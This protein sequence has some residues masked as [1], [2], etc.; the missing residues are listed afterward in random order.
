[1]D[2]NYLIEYID[3]RIE[4]IDKEN[5]L[6]VELEENI[7]MKN[8]I[9]LEIDD[10]KKNMNL[11]YGKYLKELDK[12]IG[13]G[14]VKQELKKLINYLIFVKKTKNK[15]HL[16]NINLNMV[17]RGNPGTGKTTVARIVAKILCELGFLKS[18]CVIETTPRDFIAGYIGQTAIQSRETI[19]KAKGGV[20]F[21][22]EAYTFAQSA[23]DDGKTFVYEAITEIIKEMESGNTAFIFS[24]YSKEMDKFIELNPGIK[25]RIA[26][27]IN[28][29]NYTK[30]ELFKMFDNKV[31][32]AGLGAVGIK[33]D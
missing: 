15:V 8:K 4:E 22:D 13:L 5:N 20:I 29:V 12:L 31:K 24:G 2:V 1:M 32:D 21:I 26:Y 33:D 6:A 10:M 23:S 28:F 19:A 11:V 27:D 9:Q 18:N 14:E 3:K 30:E 25:S 16:D 7:N 17:F